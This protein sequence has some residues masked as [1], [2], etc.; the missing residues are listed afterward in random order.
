MLLLYLLPIQILIVCG[1]N[2]NS[3]RVG[4]ARTSWRER[5]ERERKRCIAVLY[6]SLGV[7]LPSL[8]LWQK[9]IVFVLSE[10]KVGTWVLRRKRTALYGR[11]TNTVPKLCVLCFEP[12]VRPKHH[13]QKWWWW[14][15]YLKYSYCSGRF[16]LCIDRDHKRSECSSLF[17]AGK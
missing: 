14:K 11:D 9:P 3:N 5:W 8:S 6:I 4:R 16:P 1:Q 12:S 7:S 15:N 2:V 13:H 10:N 17:L